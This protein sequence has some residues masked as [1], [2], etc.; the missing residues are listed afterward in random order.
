MGWPMPF[1]AGV[2]CDHSPGPAF[3]R[4]VTAG[5]GPCVRRL[6]EAGVLRPAASTLPV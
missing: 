6:L 5:Y 3:C 2:R 1:A 4:V